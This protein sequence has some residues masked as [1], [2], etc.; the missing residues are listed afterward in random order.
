MYQSDPSIALDSEAA[1]CM[2]IPEEAIKYGL[3]INCTLEMAEIGWNSTEK[4]TLAWKVTLAQYRN[5]LQ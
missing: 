2:W 4:N 1:Q 5:T 3:K